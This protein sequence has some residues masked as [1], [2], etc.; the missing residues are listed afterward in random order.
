MRAWHR[1]VSDLCARPHVGSLCTFGAGVGYYAL[2]DIATRHT[3]R[4]LFGGHLA[5]AAMIFY[6]M[7]VAPQNAI[8]SLFSYLAMHLAIAAILYVYSET[9]AKTVAHA[10]VASPAKRSPGRPRKNPQA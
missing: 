8:S 3:L 10:K 5:F 6:I 7:Q 2:S 9:S 1:F 4:V